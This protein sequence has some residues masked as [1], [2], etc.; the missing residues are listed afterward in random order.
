MAIVTHEFATVDAA[1]RA[2]RALETAGVTPGAT[3]GVTLGDA[4]VAA[5]DAPDSA[6]VTVRVDDAQAEHVRTILQTGHAAGL[7]NGASTTLGA[8]PAETET[9]ARRDRETGGQ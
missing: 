3:L 6:I 2:V 9:T 4:S 8:A 7:S 1:T 5:G